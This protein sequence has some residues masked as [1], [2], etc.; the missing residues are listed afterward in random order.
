MMHGAMQSAQTHVDGRIGMVPKL[1]GDFVKVHSVLPNF[2]ADVPTADDLEDD[3][4]CLGPNAGALHGRP[5][6]TSS[7]RIRVNIGCD[8]ACSS[9]LIEHGACPGATHIVPFGG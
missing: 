8:N 1:G 3:V 7:R 5:S 9:L 2:V 6:N 4:A